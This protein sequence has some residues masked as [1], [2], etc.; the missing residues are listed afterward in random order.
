[1]RKTITKV[2]LIISAVSVALGVVLCISGVV[3][4][5][6]VQKALHGIGVDVDTRIEQND[7]YDDY[8]DEINDFF[9]EFGIDNMEGD[10]NEETV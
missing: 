7:M 2:V 3:M 10:Y 4:G 6:D 1:M 9:R 8:D 5:A